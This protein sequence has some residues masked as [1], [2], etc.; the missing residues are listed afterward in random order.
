M[1]CLL[2][3]ASSEL[4]TMRTREPWANLRIC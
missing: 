2:S 4:Q 1:K 3:I